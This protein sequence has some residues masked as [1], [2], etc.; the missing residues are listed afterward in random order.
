VVARR[1]YQ[2][3]IEL[4]RVMRANGMHDALNGQERALMKEGHDRLHAL[5][6]SLK[7][8]ETEGARP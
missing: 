7:T 8:L 2:W 4:D 6:R 1:A 3:M 5:Y